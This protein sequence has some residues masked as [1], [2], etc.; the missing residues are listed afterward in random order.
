VCSKFYFLW[1]DKEPNF[2][3]DY[4]CREL[5]KEL[6]DLVGD[7]DV[8]DLEKKFHDMTP[9]KFA[10]LETKIE[11][12]LERDNLLDKTSKEIPFSD[13]EGP[14]PVNNNKIDDGPPIRMNNMGD[15]NKPMVGQSVSDTTSVP[16]PKSGGFFSWATSQPPMSLI[17]YAW[18]MMAVGGLAGWG[19]SKIF[20][21][22]SNSKESEKNGGSHV[23]TQMQPRQSS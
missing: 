23:Q 15:L 22:S 10:A 20:T 1:F 5:E 4:F 6:E 16:P 12:I 17:G 7:M 21:Q 11:R 13:E 9:A 19:L 18:G 2:F 3:F 8:E 14:A